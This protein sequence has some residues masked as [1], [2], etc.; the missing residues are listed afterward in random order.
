MKRQAATRIVVASLAVALAA[1]ALVAGLPGTRVQGT[2]ES[3]DDEDRRF[4]LS[5][6][7]EEPMVFHW[8]GE[9]AMLTRPSVGL[10]M[11]IYY[12]TRDDGRR[13]ALRIGKAR[14]PS[15]R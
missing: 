4:T 10:E 8:N 1:S 3:V 5:I 7:G 2:V 6:E 15:R 9:T 14:K 12:V 13:V 11:R